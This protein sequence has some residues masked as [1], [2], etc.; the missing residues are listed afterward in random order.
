MRRRWCQTTAPGLKAIWPPA[1]QQPPADVDVVAGLAEL[2]VEAAD[3]LQRALAERHV[4]AGDVLGVAI[5]DQD[6]RRPARRVARRTAA[7]RPS[8]G[9]GTF[10]PPTRGVRVGLRTPRRGASASPDR[11]SRRRRCRR[12]SRRS[13]PR[14]AGVARGRRG[15]GCSVSITRTPSKRPRDLRRVVGRAVVDD[16]HLVV[17]VVERATPSR[18][19]RERRRRRCRCRRRRTSAAGVARGASGGVANASPTAASAGFGAR[20]RS[21]E[22]EV[23]V[24]DLVAAAVPLVG[25]GEDERARAAGLVARLELPAQRRAPAPPRR[26]GG[27]RARSRPSAAAGRRPGSAAGPGSARGPRCSLR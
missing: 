24:E 13:P 12:R 22:A 23:P 11:G 10:G 26:C 15:R 5:A 8:P 2:R 16:D 17:G 6:V 21:V 1:S 19:S 14:I 27:C 20:S 18:H 4:A 25:P 9:G 7:T 3:L